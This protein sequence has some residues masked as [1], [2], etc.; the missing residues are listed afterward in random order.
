MFWEQEIETMPEE[1][2]R[3]LQLT[4]LREAVARAVQAP[5]YKTLLGEEH[6]SPDQIRTLDDLRRIPFTTKEHLRGHF[7]YGFLG[8]PQEEIIRLHSS[9]GTTGNPTVIYHTREDIGN[10]ADLVARCMYTVGVRNTD[11]FQNMMGYGLFTGG[12]GLHYGAEKLGAMT[13]PAGAGNSR[14]QIWLMQHFGTTV[15]HIVPSYA[16]HLATVFEELEVDPKQ[17]V[18]L[19]IAFIGAEPHSESTRGRLEELYGIRAYNSYGLSEMNGPGVA[20]ECVEQE[21]L[22]VW[23]DTYILEVIDRDTLEPVK[24]GEEGELVFTHLTRRGTPLLRYRT[25]DLAF[26]Y[27]EPCRCG[28]T[29]RRISRIRGRADDMLI[30]KGVNIFPIQIERTLMEIPEVGNNYLIVLERKD[31]VDDMIVRI[32][33]RSEVLAGGLRQLERLRR[34][35]VARLRDEILI[36]PKIELVEPNTLPTSEGKAVRV[37]DNR[38]I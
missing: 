38:E 20:F 27:P 7:P 11:V 35:I 15:L 17:D 21:G 5:Y 12:L 1:D 30:V 4:R 19:R 16:L 8:V 26:V 34:H 13:I 28:R 3:A 37:I 10:W 32:E 18:H 6:L 33:V 25:K 24:E 22:H 2:L 14:R 23:E 36:T 9:S 29:H 31:D